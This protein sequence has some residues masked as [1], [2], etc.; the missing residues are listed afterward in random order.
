MQ[1]IPILLS[2]LSLTVGSLGLMPMSQALAQQ[3][4][5]TVTVNQLGA[6]FW[7]WGMEP[8]K[9]QISLQFRGAGKG[10]EIR[11]VYLAF[12]DYE[13]GV[14]ET[15][16]DAGIEEL[17]STEKPEWAAKVYELTFDGPVSP[18]EPIVT[19]G[20]DWTELNK[21]DVLYY[22]AEYGGWEQDDGTVTERFW[23][24]GKIDYRNCVHDAA[25]EAGRATTCG[26]RH[27]ESATII[28]AESADAD[29]EAEKISWPK[30]VEGIVRS[31][32]KDENEMVDGWEE[33]DLYFEKEIID[34]VLGRVKKHELLATESA[35]VDE[36]TN[37]I[38]LLVARIL[39][40]Q[41]KVDEPVIGG[42]EGGD[43]GDEEDD[44]AGGKPSGDGDETGGSSDNGGQTGD[45]SEVGTGGDQTEVGGDQVEGGGQTG[46]IEGDQENVGR[47][48]ARPNQTPGMTNGMQNEQLEANGSQDGR[49]D[50]GN[51]SKE[52]EIVGKEEGVFENGEDAFGRE[53]GAKDEVAV[54]IL[55]GKQESD[56]KW[57]WWLILV[58]GVGGA[59]T[60][61]VKR[62]F[63]SKR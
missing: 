25:F 19:T 38:A 50:L 21:R 32:L 6:P 30:E 24:R 4:T 34:I 42:N 22:A 47:P 3:Q 27:G 48:I 43:D 9:G 37:E 53:E 26:F 59:I 33:Q 61:W 13:K 8:Q 7:A 52:E 44:D 54:P 41:K 31:R 28:Y 57:L 40:R 62:A 14:T 11:G 1:K 10:N 23:K 36:I 35:N 12:Y 49:G 58:S 18:R 45:G 46:P 63:F 29:S 2:T 60:I 5:P 51:S 15:Q 17:G 16:A 20:D 39:K 55:G 56:K